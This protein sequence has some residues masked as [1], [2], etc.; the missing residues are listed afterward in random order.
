VRF[1]SRRV[2]WLALVLA[3]V[4]CGLLPEPP[5]PTSGPIAFAFD[6]ENRT[7]RTLIVS[8]ASDAA[9]AMPEFVGGQS[10]TVSITVADPTNG[11]GVE[12][13]AGPGCDILANGTFPTPRPFTLVIEDAADPSTVRLSARPTVASAAMPQPRDAGRCSG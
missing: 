1:V 5:P 4:G 11:I 3:V 2:G 13:I 8:V 6:V 7:Q 12:V 9:A 10:G